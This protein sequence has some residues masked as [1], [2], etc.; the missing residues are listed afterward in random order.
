MVSP[1]FRILSDSE[2]IGTSHLDM[3]EASMGIVRGK[4]QP[5]QRY[6]D[7]QPIFRLYTDGMLKGS[8]VK[9]DLNEYYQKRDQLHLR[10]KSP[11]GDDIPVLTVHI[12]DLSNEGFE[13]EVEI[14]LQDSKTYQQYFEG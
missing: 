3:H 2:V 13:S 6:K 1:P 14:I 12:I 7:V 8:G 4:F 11:D 5:T 9:I 10:L